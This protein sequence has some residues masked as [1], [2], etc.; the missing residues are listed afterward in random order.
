MTTVPF[1]HTDEYRDAHARVCMM[2]D[3]QLIALLSET[4]GTMTETA[5]L[6]ELDQRNLDDSR[7]Y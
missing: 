1:R 5:I 6:D 3:E 7:G 4:E 2:Q